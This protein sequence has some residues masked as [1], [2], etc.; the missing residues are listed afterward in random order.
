MDDIAN[1]ITN[2]NSKS[3][4][5]QEEMVYQIVL[6]EKFKEVDEKID[7]YL[8]DLEKDKDKFFKP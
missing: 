1:N 8:S 3:Y 6:D 4:R 5:D 7:K 2:I